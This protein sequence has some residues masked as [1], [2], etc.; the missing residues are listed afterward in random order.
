M[1][2]PDITGDTDPLMPRAL[3]Q[4]AQSRPT[5]PWRSILLASSPIVLA[6]SSLGDWLILTPDT[7]RYLEAARCLYETGHFPDARLVFPPLFPIALAPLMSF[8]HLPLLA[9]RILLILAWATCGVLA[10]HMYR[11]ELGRWPAWIV[12]LLVATHSDM[13]VQSATLLSEL[14]YMP[15]SLGALL[16][17]ARWQERNHIGAASL[18]A[19]ALLA[20]ATFMTRS[21]G[22]MLLPVGVLVLVARSRDPWRT[23]LLRA[24]VF[25]SLALLVMFAWNRRENHYSQDATYSDSLVR[26]R[27]VEHTHAT[28]ARLQLERFVHFGG[29]RLDEITS[30]VLP[31]RVCWPLLTSTWGGWIQWAV[32]GVVVGLLLLRVVWKRKPAEAYGLLLLALLAFWPWDEGVRFVLPLLPIFAG[33]LMWAMLK[34]WRWTK[35]RRV[36]RAAAIAVGCAIVLGFSIEL[37][38]ARGRFDDARRKALDRLAEMRGLADRLHRHL[39]P[40]ATI[41]CVTPDGDPSKTQLTGAAYAAHVVACHY[42]DVYDADLSHLPPLQDQC[43]FVH[44]TLADRAE[45]M[46]G[47][48]RQ[49]DVKQFAVFIPE[50]R[51]P[52]APGAN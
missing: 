39:P 16:V 20:T 2:F 36:M 25:G 27:P 31:R 32:G 13:L 17:F 19:G 22:V 38:V 48:R 29:Q 9:V 15:L 33:S 8:G 4:T 23:R 52:G 47:A 1:S 21:M 28:G 50:P 11:R 7:F 44:H 42:L 30:I 12:G 40:N 41:L 35:T 37:T 5:W 43:V 18:L 51:R 14:V 45:A 24:A 10:Y 26:A 6:A 46:W 34:I 3:S 49:F